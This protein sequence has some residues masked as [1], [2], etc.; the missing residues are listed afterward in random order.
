MGTNYAYQEYNRNVQHESAHSVC[1]QS[2]ESNVVKIAHGHLWDFPDK[3]YHKV[4]DG[5]N[6]REV[7]ERHQWVHL[8]FGGAEKTLNHDNT[9]GLEDDTSDLEQ[10]TNDNE[11][12]F[13]N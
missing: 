6:W 3:C 7:V 4:H 9:D 10:D 5:T 11:V 8:E 2:P 1:K 13:S 12:N